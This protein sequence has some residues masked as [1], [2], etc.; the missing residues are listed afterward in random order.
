MMSS[1]KTSVGD[2]KS[3][4]K[5]SAAEENKNERRTTVIDW[6]KKQSYSSPRNRSTDGQVEVIDQAIVTIIC[7]L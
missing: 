3:E 2:N 1:A 5:E 7:L 4:A 6:A